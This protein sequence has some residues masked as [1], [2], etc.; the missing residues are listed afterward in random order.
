MGCRTGEV[1]A[2]DASEFFEPGPD[3]TLGTFM[4]LGD[5]FDVDFVA[6]LAEKVLLLFT[7]DEVGPWAFHCHILYHMERGMFRVVQVADDDGSIYGQDYT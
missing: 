5:L 4:F 7:A 1:L 2:L 3:G 6:E